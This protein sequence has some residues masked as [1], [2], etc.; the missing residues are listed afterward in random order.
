M[1]SS[2]ENS[3]KLKEELSDNLAMLLLATYLKEW[4]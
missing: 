4:T 2:M 3:P 1:E